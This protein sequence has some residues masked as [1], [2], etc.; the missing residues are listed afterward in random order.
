MLQGILM[1]SAGN[2]TNR[3]ASTSGRPTRSSRRPRGHGWTGTAS[4]PSRCPNRRESTPPT[5]PSRPP[6]SL[7][8]L[9]LANPVVAEIARTRTVELPGAGEVTNT[10]DLLSDPGVV[11]LKTGSLAAFYNLLAA[12]DITVG[13]TPV[14]VY[15]T[16]RPAH[17]GGARS[18][19]GAS[20]VRGHHRGLDTLT[21]PAGTLA[22][23]VSTAWGRRRTS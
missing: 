1:G 19:D 6:W 11:G 16:A 18:G 9:A 13:T 3:L 15:A 8:Q 23:V 5:P 12:K 4:G 22:G 7:A 14:R 10:N 2:Y 20:A 21:L 17:G